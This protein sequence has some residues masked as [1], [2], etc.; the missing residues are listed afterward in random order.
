MEGLNSRIQEIKRRAK[1]FRNID[2][3]I[4]II[5]LEVGGLDLKVAYDSKMS[6]TQNSEAPKKIK[7]VEGTA[8]PRGAWGGAPRF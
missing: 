1:G 4:A 7:G 6:P 2:N 8:S 5:Y 3:F